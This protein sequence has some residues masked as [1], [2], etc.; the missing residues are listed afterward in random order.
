MYV[1]TLAILLNEAVDKLRGND[2]YNNVDLLN[3]IIKDIG[4]RTQ[5]KNLNK[6]SNKLLNTLNFLGIRNAVQLLK[7]AFIINTKL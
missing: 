1:S 2:E 6:W 5:V 3:D 4:R 7:S